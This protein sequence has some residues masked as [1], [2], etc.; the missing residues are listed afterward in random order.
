MLSYQSIRE[1]VGRCQSEVTRLNVA[2]LNAGMVR[3]EFII[4]ESTGHEQMF[5]VNYLS[6]AL[7][8]LLLLPVLT[9]KRDSNGP[10]SRLTVV[11]SGMSLLSKFANHQSNPLIPTFD[12]EKGWGI[13]A[14]SEQYGVTK[15]LLSSF[16]LTL[17]SRVR[18]ADVIIN[19][20]DPGLVGG[21]S[22]HRTIKGPAKA[23]MALMKAATARSLEQ[24]AW[25]YVD[26]AVVKGAESHGSF[27]MDWKIAP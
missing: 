27:V 11:S 12:N 26:A 13:N 25:T 8:S 17:S 3:S 22:L 18:A 15:T 7:L 1:F 2:V 6:T 24:G 4:N 9:T 14:A 20:V 16:M 19:T 5:Q 23:V 21:S 10:P